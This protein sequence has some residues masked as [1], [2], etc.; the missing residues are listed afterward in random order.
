M[1]LK[2]TPDPATKRGIRRM[3]FFAVISLTMLTGCKNSNTSEETKP[4]LPQHADLQF[5][6]GTYTKGESKGIYKYAIS[7]EGKL[8]KIGLAAKTS[9]PSYLI[10]N[11][12]KKILLTVNENDHGTVQSFLIENDSL[13]LLSESSSGG[14][15]PCHISINEKGYVLVA[16]Y[17]A[18]NVGLLQLN[19]QGKLSGLLDLAQHSGKGTTERQQG[20]HAHFADFFDD[21]KKI[22]EVDLGTNQLWFDELNTGLKKLEPATVRRVDLPKGAGPRH[23]VMHPDKPFMYVLNELSSSISLF[24]TANDSINILDTWSTLPKDYSAFNTGG[25]LA[26]TQDAK[27]LYASNR[28]LNSIAVFRI[29]DDGSL[30]LLKNIP[31]QGEMPRNFSL[32]P[33]D[34]FLVVAN[35]DSNN[36]IAF[37]R[38]R[39]TGLL[40]FVSQIDAPKPVCIVFL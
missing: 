31:S 4:A 26:I 13:I 36:L 21:N 24:S 20:P 9:N 35:E 22:I 33:N 8:S 40:T 25:E 19:D 1:K 30:K 11:K 23:V 16:N 18:G 37:K 5:Y 3:T 14:A 10:L 28:G 27:F 29:T 17:T 32:T 6:V 12:D 38:D 39:E 7:S 15:H 2:K 34:D